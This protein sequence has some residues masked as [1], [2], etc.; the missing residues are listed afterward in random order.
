MFCKCLNHFKM[1]LMFTRLCTTPRS[2]IIRKHKGIKFY[3]YAN[4]S[5][6]Y[7]HLSKKNASTA[8][9]KLNRCLDDV[10]EWM[11]TSKLKLNPEKTKFII[12]GSKG[13]RDKLNACF[14]IDI[15]GSPLCPVDSVKTL[16]VW[17]D[18]DFFLVQACSECLQKLFC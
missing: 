9:E 12:F 10:K 18:S 3:F 2:V 11:S 1:F 6:V 17:F 8:F 4:D 15:L 13:Q 16:G 7:A 14:S 5:Q